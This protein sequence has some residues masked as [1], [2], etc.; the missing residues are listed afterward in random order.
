MNTLK[1]LRRNFELFCHRNRD[2]GISNLM[3]YIVLGTGLVYVLN[4]ING[5]GAL[6]SF[7][8]FDKQKILQGQV[9]RLFTWI[10]T[11]VLSSNPLLN[12]LFL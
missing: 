1:H 10:L 4:L 8:L 5:G 9:W 11:D 12:V 7:L 3:L 2:K 6:T